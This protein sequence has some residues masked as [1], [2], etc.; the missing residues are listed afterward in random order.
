MSA[1]SIA[2]HQDTVDEAFFELF[3]CVDESE[4]ADADYYY[5]SD[6]GPCLSIRCSHDAAA[7]FARLL[8][9]VLCRTYRP[10][11]PAALR[12]ASPDELLQALADTQTEP[13]VD[14][15]K[16]TYWPRIQVM[17]AVYRGASGR[18][19]ASADPI[20]RGIADTRDVEIP[21]HHHETVAG[22]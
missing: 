7:E 3:G 13:A 15:M 12:E 19:G 1:S 18:S 17:R 8:H 4:G 5:A 10:D 16:T 22:Y 9:A 20:R 11:R 14:G 2:L 6:H 21:V